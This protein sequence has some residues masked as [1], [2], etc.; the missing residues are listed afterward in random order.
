MHTFP[1][2][3][4][5]GWEIYPENLLLPPLESNVS[6]INLKLRRRSN[7]LFVENQK[8]IFWNLRLGLPREDGTRDAVVEQIQSTECLTEILSHSQETR[9]FFINQRFS[10]SR[11]YISEEHF[12]RLFTFLRVHPNFLDTVFLFSAKIGPEEEGYSSF[13]VDNDPSE[14]GNK[15][16]VAGE[17]SGHYIGYN[18]KYVARHGRALPKDPFS[19]R[20]IGVYQHYSSQTGKCEWVFLQAPDQLKACLTRTFK[21]CE[22]TLPIKQHMLHALVLLHVSDGWREYLAHLEEQFSGLVDKGFYTKVKGTQQEGGISLDFSDLRKLHVLTDKLRRLSHLL[23]LNIRVGGQLKE[24][25]CRLGTAPSGDSRSGVISIQNKL[26]SF[27]VG[28]KIS[29]DRVE[30]L[31]LRSNGIGQLVQSINDTRAVDASNQINHEM[32]RLTEQG[33]EESKLMKKLTEKS[34]RD[35]RSMMVIALISAVFLP[36][37][38]LATLFG[39]NFF[40][41][42]EH[43]H[44]LVIASNFWVYILIT[45]GFSC[46][47]LLSWYVWRRRIEQSKALGDQE[48]L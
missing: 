18:I 9:M 41:F 4:Y 36:A 5:H 13:F 47:S 42:S 23:R 28:Q 17:L 45:T 20:E 11:L 2:D 31:I 35:T 24:T 3:M 19:I 39:S 30:S 46:L 15:P 37:T 26:N 29:A 21:C 44:S 10:W 6:N 27:L 33:I 16:A 1:A 43:D 38:F 32:K 8:S 25:L 14:A 40:D 12:R 22:A 48:S 34:A 7:E